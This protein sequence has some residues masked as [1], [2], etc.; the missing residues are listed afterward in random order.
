MRFSKT[1]S[2]TETSLLCAIAALLLTPLA[3][4]PGDETKS[5]KPYIVVILI[6][7]QSHKL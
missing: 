1:G 2:I 4:L 5:A 3:A 7:N 6:G